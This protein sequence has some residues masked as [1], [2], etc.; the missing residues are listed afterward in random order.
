MV[1][2]DPRSLR[3]KLEREL[4]EIAASRD[5]LDLL[6]R[7]DELENRLRDAE[8][9]APPK[10]VGRVLLLEDVAPGLRQAVRHFGE[11]VESLEMEH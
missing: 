7:E 2:A 1:S 10:G 3:G 4:A 11:L 9:I 6:V 8:A 5:V